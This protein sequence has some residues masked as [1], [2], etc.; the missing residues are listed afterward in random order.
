[1]L[2]SEQ[3]G[4]R[5][6]AFDLMLN[7]GVHAHLLEPMQSEEQQACGEEA[8]SSVQST[9]LDGSS[10][11]S[12]LEIETYGSGVHKENGSLKTSLEK[13]ERGTPV[14]VGQF[15][16][17]LLDILC[18]M[19][20]FLVQSEEMEEGVWASALSC[21]LYMSPGV[22]EIQAVA[23][24]L[25]QAEAPEYF[26]LA[27][28][29]G[30]QGVGEAISKSI[31]TAMSQD[32]TNGRLNAQLLEDVT[33]SLDMLASEHTQPDV[34]FKLL[35]KV[36]MLSEGLTSG[37]VIGTSALARD[38]TLDPALVSK[39]WATLCS[40]SLQSGALLITW[41]NQPVIRHGF[42][43]VLEKLLVQCQ[44]PGL[45]L[46]ST[47]PPSW[48][49]GVTKDGLRSVG[50]QHRALAMLG[51][52]NGALW[53]VISANDA[54][55]INILQELWV[56]LEC[57]TLLSFCYSV[58]ILEE[59][60]PKSLEMDTQLILET[61]RMM[62]TIVISNSKI[63]NISG[64][65]VSLHDSGRDNSSMAAMLL[66]GQAAAP[67]LLVANMPTALLYW[68]L[69]QLAASANDDV[70]LGIA[71]GSRGGGTV[72]GG[73]CDVRAA[74]LLLLIG[75]CNAYQAAL[76]EVG[77]NEFVRSLLDDLDARIAYYTSAF[78]L[79]GMMRE[80]PE[81]YQ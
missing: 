20:L 28:K 4:V 52:M 75:K 54:D 38:S 33:R 35:I 8:A 60:K 50:E 46:E 42:V 27:F 41:S 24:T 59:K 74:L 19:L 36:T 14:A 13:P 48:E 68:P 78:L 58:L 72:Q 67:K 5:V 10:L 53:Q 73:T 79:K 43:L 64:N 71:V 30:L 81:T 11:S 25:A 45:E 56:G 37:D 12:P 29:Q 32:V 70:V 31:V 61:R 16:A 21:L 57:T 51:L 7:L 15:E 76:D 40:S 44:R 3:V 62:N 23:T 49:E 39:A 22:E 2:S 65:V 1:M 66:S 63:K 9:P 69:M 77:G 6:C 80:E 34:E 18:E 17:W 26:A 55:R 47:P